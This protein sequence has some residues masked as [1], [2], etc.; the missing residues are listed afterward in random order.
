MNRHVEDIKEIRKMMEQSARFI[1]LSGMSGVVVGAIALLGV[2]ALV[3][4]FGIN[5]FSPF[6]PQYSEDFLPAGF[7]VAIVVL[8]LSLLTASAFTINR[9][10]KLGIKVWDNTAKR[11]SINLMVPLV[12]GGLFCI[13]LA[14]H[15][16]LIFL[17]PASL[18]F[19]GLSLINASKYTLQEIRMM[20]VLQSLLGLLAMFI[21]QYSLIFW[22]VGFGFVHI[23]YGLLMYNKYERIH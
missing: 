14:L 20:G 7:V 13:A 21:P 9:S 1:S 15:G 4:H 17:A 19:Y 16:G 5:L 3:Y 18:V 23:V 8:V 22:A 2:A 12:V 10:K 11:L 6:Y